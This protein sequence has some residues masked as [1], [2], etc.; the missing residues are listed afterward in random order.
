[1]GKSPGW[2]NKWHA[3]TEN[4]DDAERSG[5][6][7]T[8][9]TPKN[10]KH[11]EDCE[12]KTGQSVRIVGERL[13]MGK[14][15]A[16]RGF[17]EVGLTSYRR[18]KQSKLTDKHEEMRFECAMKHKDKPVTFWEDILNTDEKLWDTNGYFNAQNDQVR[19]K[20]AE[21]VNPH[22][23]EKFPGKRMS[24]L[25]VTPRGTTGIH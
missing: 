13:G 23:L 7:R 9:L 19:A 3:E 14:T 2:V 10:L 4:F 25:G 8:A 22:N 1:M 16:S 15:S 20:K 11:L 12:G 17:K 21:D 5:R 6:T 18:P 24:W